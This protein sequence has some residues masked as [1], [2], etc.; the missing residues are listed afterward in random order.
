MHTVDIVAELPRRSQ[1]GAGLCGL[2]PHL[3]TSTG[4]HLYG[5][6]LCGPVAAIGCQPGSLYDYPPASSGPHRTQVRCLSPPPHAAPPELPP[7]VFLDP[8]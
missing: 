4:Q 3:G 5:K 8:L 7:P 2:P 6:L 1:Q